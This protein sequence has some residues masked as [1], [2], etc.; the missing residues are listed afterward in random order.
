VLSVW[1]PLHSVTAVSSG[2]TWPGTGQVGTANLTSNSAVAGSYA[3]T[4]TLNADG[5]WSA[6]TAAF[7][8]ASSNNTARH[9][10][11]QGAGFR[12]LR[13]PWDRPRKMIALERH[14]IE[15]I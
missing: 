4:W 5:N 11:I 8:Q 7:A 15:K 13:V 1:D 3:P 12:I 2:W 9:L 10:I 14:Q 6:V